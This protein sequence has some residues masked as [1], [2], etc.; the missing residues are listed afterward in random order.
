MTRA[1]WWWLGSAVIAIAVVA[2]LLAMRHQPA[3]T[4]DDTTAPN[5]PLATAR[6]AASVRPRVAARRCRSRK[7]GSCMRSTCA[8]DKP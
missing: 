3:T 1:S 2:T 4:A 6:K 5:V 7:P 8:S